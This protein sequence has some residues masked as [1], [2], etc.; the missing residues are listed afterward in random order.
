MQARNPRRNAFGSID[1]E[2]EHPSLGWIAFTADPDDT[3]PH[4]RQLYTAAMNGQFGEV[5]P[6]VPPP[7]PP[8]QVPQT[9]SRFQARAA[10]HIAGLLDQVN[11]LM[12]DPETPMLSRLAWQDAQEF[13][14]QSP[15]VLTMAAALGLSEEDVDNLFITAAQVQA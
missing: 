3:E 11:T 2:L 12:A 4:G 13:R 14:R 10:L 9:V 7:A 1:L 6:Y 8:R 15:T 5:A